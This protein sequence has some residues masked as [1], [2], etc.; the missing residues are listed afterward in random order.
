MLMTSHIYFLFLL[1]AV[2]TSQVMTLPNLKVN[3]LLIND[4]IENCTCTMTS[5]MYESK[6][7][8]LD[9]QM[10]C[11]FC[12]VSDWSRIEENALFVAEDASRHWLLG[13]QLVIICDDDITVTSR[14]LEMIATMIDSGKTRHLK[15]FD[16]RFTRDHVTSS[17]R[18]SAMTLYGLINMTRSVDGNLTRV[19]LLDDDLDGEIARYQDNNIVF[20]NV[21]VFQPLSQPIKSFNL[22]FADD[23]ISSEKILGATRRAEDSDV[24]SDLSDFLVTVIYT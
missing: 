17:T 12:E 8:Y 14:H 7:E 11:D 9:S 5:L 16:C 19:N 13:D 3:L 4:V 18:K 1:A 10:S 24:M 15:I 23:V 21:T 22:N 20:I 2:M 6:K